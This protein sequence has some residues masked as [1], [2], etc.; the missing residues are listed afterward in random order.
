MISLLNSINELQRCHESQDLARDCYLGAIRNI[1][2]YAVNLEPETTSLYRKYL[3]DVAVQVSGG[4]IEVLSE[5]RASVRGLLRDYRDQAAQYLNK[6]RQELSDSVSALEQTLDALGQTDGD[7]D[8]QL[9]SAIARLRALPEAN[10]GRVRETVLAAAATIEGSLDQVRKQHKL[11]VS[12]FLIEIRMLHKRIDAMESA[13]SIDTLTQLFNREEMEARIR[14]AQS[15]KLSFLLLKV[16]GLRAAELQFGRVV[17]E[18]LAAAFT[19]RL[20]NTLPATAVVGRWSEEEFLAMLQTDQPEAAAI[21]KRISENL[22]GAYAC[23][24]EGKTVRPAI[25]LR[26]GIVDPRSDGTERV[27]ERIAEFLNVA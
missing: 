23:L 25:Q 7:H 13:A 26:V 12:Q 8:V 27:L 6:L 2:Q 24:K 17:A 21:A 18:E 19:K 3:E 9:R 15:T 14:S 20:R 16:G 5:S 4:S 1:A 22:A 11:T 10:G